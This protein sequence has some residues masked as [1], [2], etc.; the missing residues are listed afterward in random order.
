MMWLFR[1]SQPGPLDPGPPHSLSTA[2]LSCDFPAQ[3]PDTAISSLT[4]P[5]DCEGPIR[6]CDAMRWAKSG[7]GRARQNNLCLPFESNLKR[8]KT[9]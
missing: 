4:L 8:G 5:N 2:K 7:M 6:G 9:H 3:I 1:R